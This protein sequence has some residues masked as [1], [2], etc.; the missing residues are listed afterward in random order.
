[1]LTQ[2]RLKELLLYDPDTGEFAKIKW[3]RLGRSGIVSRGKN[4]VGYIQIR[5]DDVLYVGHR[6]AWLYTYGHFPKTLDH[7]NGDKSDNRICNIRLVTTSQN[8]MNRKLSKN[9]TSGT[10]G[11]C[12]RRYGWVAQIWKDGITYTKFS[13]DKDFVCAWV[14]AKRE[15][16]HGEFACDGSR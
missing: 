13:K 6:L 12:R 11:I 14:K 10:K 9:N 15:E 3:L 8:A 4:S 16:L 1:M 7:I 2:A 5:I